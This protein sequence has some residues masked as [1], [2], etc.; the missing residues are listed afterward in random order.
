MITDKVYSEAVHPDIALRWK[1][2]IKQGLPSEEKISLIKKY[3][4]PGNCIEIEA[5]KLNQEVRVA[6][7]ENNRK[8][9]DRILAKQAKIAAALAALAKATILTVRS[10]DRQLLSYI[11]DA[12]RLIADIQRDETSIRRNLAIA[13][14]NVAAKETLTATA[15]DEFLFGKDLSEKLKTAKSLEGSL[16]LLKQDSK[17]PAAKSSPKNGTAPPKRQPS[18]Q[19]TQGGKIPRS[20]SSKV[21]RRS[22][23]G[24]RRSPHRSYRR[25]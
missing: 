16:K 12:A 8:R 22:P 21:S 6:L 24:K 15:P 2:I 11:S 10:K 9:D 25:H 20:K 13:N 14:V 4:S 1:E 17:T 23:A 18:R 19:T 3:T 7:T 5:P